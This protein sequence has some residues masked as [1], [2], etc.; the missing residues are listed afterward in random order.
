MP[1]TLPRQHY[2]DRNIC[3]TCKSRQ[4]EENYSNCSICREAN[5]KWMKENRERVNI[6]NKERYDFLK[7]QGLCVTCKLPSGGNVYCRLCTDNKCRTRAFTRPLHSRN[8]W[9]KR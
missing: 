7:S 1:T 5:Q 6:R 9:S 8:R 4:L 3:P 2:L